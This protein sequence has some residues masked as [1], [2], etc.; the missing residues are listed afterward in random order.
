MFENMPAAH[1]W[2]IDKGA[3]HTKGTPSK[4][5]SQVYFKKPPELMSE[6]CAISRTI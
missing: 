1:R 4:S 5:Q 2:A 3:A 6:G